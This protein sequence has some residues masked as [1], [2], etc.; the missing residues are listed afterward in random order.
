MQCHICSS[1]LLTA[2]ESR[3][4]SADIEQIFQGGPQKV[5]HHHIVVASESTCAKVGTLCIRKV[6]LSQSKAHSH[7]LARY[8]VP[9]TARI[10]RW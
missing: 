5:H 9:R 7:I 1:V 4:P 6:H 2:P 8:F 10:L 3:P